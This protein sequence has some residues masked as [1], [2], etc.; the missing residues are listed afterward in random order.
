MLCNLR[1]ETPPTACQTECTPFN[2]AAAEKGGMGQGNEPNKKKETSFQTC[3]R[4]LA[5]FSLLDLPEI[6]LQLSLS[7][8]SEDPS[9]EFASDCKDSVNLRHTLFPFF[10]ISES[11]W[12]L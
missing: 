5:D 9:A 10:P 2:T 8:L 6:Y 12:L 7:S 4:Y 3:P 11:F 1:P